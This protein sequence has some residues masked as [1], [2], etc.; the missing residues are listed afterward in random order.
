MYPIRDI[1]IDP[2]LG[3]LT[4]ISVAFWYLFALMLI[5][6]FAV[7]AVAD[8]DTGEYD[9]V[10]TVRSDLPEAGLTYLLD[11]C[12]AT[13]GTAPD[14]SK[15]D[16]VV[17]FILKADNSS[18]PTLEPREEISGAFI[19]YTLERPLNEA[20]RYAYNQQIPE[21]AIN[22]SSV[23]YSQ[24]E[25]TPAGSVGPPELWRMLADLSKPKT[26]RG[27][28]R[29]TISPDL[30]TG[31]Y[32]EYGLKRAFLLYHRDDLRVMISISNQMGESD[33]GKKGF[34]VGDDQDWNYLYTQENGLNKGGLG[35]VKTR[36]YKFFSI[37]AYIEDLNRPGKVKIGIFQWLGA[38]W[39]GFNLVESHHIREGMERQTT[40][41][42]SL[43]ESEKMPSADT[44]ERVYQSLSR[45]DEATLREKATEVVS[46]IR[47]KAQ[48]DEK[49]M[50]KKA[51]SKLDPEAYVAKMDKDQLVSELMREF[52]KF[53]FGKETPLGAFFMVALRD[54]VPSTPMPLS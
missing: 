13:S 8:S 38:G 49:L 12:D 50:R 27:V 35:W 45:M 51:V 39:A 32:Y 43:L 41:F 37:C 14:F 18:K 11:L 7:P 36:I 6:L 17:D 1:K 24:W 47:D 20:L 42:K 26:V 54:P 3:I 34:I 52:M 21:G 31:A 28:V 40:Q 25:T 15:V 4:G 5:C 46:F 48:R 29:E 44:L 53:T 16:P 9:P 30:H 23:S 33:V 22:A 19:A 10:A 2:K